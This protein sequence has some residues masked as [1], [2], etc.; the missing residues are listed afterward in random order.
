[1]PV[2]S[3]GITRCYTLSQAAFGD[4]L[5]HPSRKGKLMAI[6]RREVLASG[7]MA[8]V[9]LGIGQNVAGSE[10]VF[11]VAKVPVFVATWPFGKV[12]CEAAIKQIAEGKSGLDAIET[13]IK[14]VE[15]DPKI[16]SVGLGGIPNAEGEVELDACIMSGPGHLAGS[17]AGLRTILHPISVARC[18]MEKTRH[19]L[20]VGEGAR[21]FAVAQ[22]FPTTE[23]VT[24]DQRQNYERWKKERAEKKIDENNHDTI[25]MVGV[26]VK[27]DVYG[28]CSTSGLA[29]KMPGRVG[30]SPIIGSG[31]YVDNRVGAAGATGIGEN[32]MR[33]CGSYMVV[34]FMRQGLSPQ[35]AC[36]QT[37]KRISQISGIPISK[38]DINFVAVNRQGD[39][40][41]AGTSAG[42]KFAVAGNGKSEVLSGLALSE[43]PI[44]PEGGNRQSPQ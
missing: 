2:W 44:G 5:R 28:G 19:V 15:G 6:N 24:D 31:L 20:L 43:K 41:A 29:F 30:D 16:D 35:D 38:L 12:A 14:L 7:T 17:V 4:Q 10:L 13:G 25:A 42:F 33:F 3:P 26:D 40:G 21:K 8:G 37:I 1:M 34:D 36:K 9:A 32:I 18:V 27:G 39:F 23:L 11:D 22:G